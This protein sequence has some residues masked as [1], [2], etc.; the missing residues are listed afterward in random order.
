MWFFLI[1]KILTF[2]YGF[3]K[4][5]NKT[6]IVS[7]QNHNHRERANQEPKTM[8]RKAKEKGLCDVIVWKN[9]LMRRFYKNISHNTW[10]PHMWV[11]QIPSQV[12]VVV[13]GGVLVGWAKVCHCGMGC[14]RECVQTNTS[15]P[16]MFYSFV[17]S[18]IH[19]P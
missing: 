19:Y 16:H 4:I 13:K 5:P 17:L 18:L 12:G 15:N 1:I 7:Y 6:L 2:V 14:K 8:M 3:T 11:T 10:V 9:Y